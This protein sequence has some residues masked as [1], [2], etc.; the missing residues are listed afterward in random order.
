MTTTVK[1]LNEG[2]CTVKVEVQ[3]RDDQGQF[4]QTAEHYLKPGEFKTTAIYREQS[5]Q[6]IEIPGPANAEPA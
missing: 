1:I 3:G 6:V 5:V 2:P 4:K